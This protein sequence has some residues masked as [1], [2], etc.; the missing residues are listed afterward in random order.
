MSAT[1]AMYWKAVVPVGGIAEGTAFINDPD[2]RFVGLDFN[3]GDLV[4]TAAPTG[5]AIA[6]RRFHGR[7]GVKLG[8]ERLE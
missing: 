8:G 5:A 4:E 2:R 1:A 7:L 3:A 6:S